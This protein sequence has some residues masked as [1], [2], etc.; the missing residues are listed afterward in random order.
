MAY[1]FFGTEYEKDELLPILKQNIDFLQSAQKQN[2]QQLVDLKPTLEQV[3]KAFD[4]M[5]ITE[6]ADERAQREKMEAV[7]KQMTQDS[8]DKFIAKK[9][10]ES[11]DFASLVAAVERDVVTIK[12]NNSLV[13][14]LFELIDDYVSNKKYSLLLALV[15]N[16]DNYI[17]N[18]KFLRAYDC[19][20]Q[21][22]NHFSN[23]KFG[24]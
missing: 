12:T 18:E 24:E 23:Q 17:Q 1:K 6:S 14:K 9:R 4:D 2:V 3:V 21:A 11:A 7:T 16:M 13:T 20:E 15:H 10:E 5:E 22:Y 19:F 8:I